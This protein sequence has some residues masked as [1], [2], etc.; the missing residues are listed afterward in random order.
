MLAVRR[1]GIMCMRHS[2]FSSRRRLTRYWRDWSSDV[3]SSDLAARAFDIFA[4]AREVDARRRRGG[5]VEVREEA[6]SAA[7]PVYYR[8]NFHY[9]S[10]GW[11]T[12]ESARRY[13]GQVEM[14]FSGAGGAMRRRALS[15]LAVAWLER[16]QRGLKLVDIACGSGAFLVDL[17]GAFPRASVIGLDLSHAYVSE[18]RGRSGAP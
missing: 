15:L 16:D 14:L 3:C 5:A 13:E 9:Q 10:G 12:P 18:A 11:F 17:K 6:D 7:Y 4:D 2:F 8:Q 1:V